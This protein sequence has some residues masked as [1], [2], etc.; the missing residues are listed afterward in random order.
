MQA[1]SPDSR[2]PLTQDFPNSVFQILVVDDDLLIHKSI[3]MA[4]PTQW[5]L[6]SATRLDE[7]PDQRFFHAACV[8]MHLSKDVS[9]P[10]DGP[11]IVQKLRHLNEQTEIIGMSGDL[12]LEL[13]ES[14]LKFGAQKFLSKPILKDELLLILEK[15]EA[16]WR[17]RTHQT[18]SATVKW[19]GNSAASQNI[20]KRISELKSVETP[21]LI[22]GDTG[23]GKEVV[24]KLLHAQEGPRPLVIVNL[25][26]IAENLF[27]S[28]FFGHIKGAFSGAT[29]NKIGLVEAANGGDLFMDEIEALHPAHQPKLLRFL[30]NGEVK[31]VGAKETSLVQVRVIAASNINL[32]E[33]VHKGLFREDLYYRL[34]ANQ[35]QLP[36]LKDRAMDI[37]QLCAHF[38]SLEKVKKTKSIS[39]DALELMK[40]YEWPGNTRELKR[41]CE[42]I[43]LAS[44]L[45]IIRSADVAPLLGI[46][47]D[48]TLKNQPSLPFDL[49]DS[50]QIE[51]GF[52]ELV[53]VFET[54][55]IKIALKKYPDVERAAEVLK[56]SRSNLYKKMKDYK[57]NS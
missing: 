44:P 2:H 50:L 20:Q 42:Q 22:E 39:H 30:E 5:K 33:M 8:D 49:K 29:Q 10:P 56:V 35:I 27:E 25:G 13:M 12:S 40:K 38:F 41:I 47:T 16:L 36:K 7:I 15:V 1:Q 4:L 45:P 19:I 11:K 37:E 48:E 21:V 6:T 23:T 54:Q 3:K 9:Q 31:K 14:C 52:E 26:A 34:C 55:L 53:Q 28:E 24:A 46:S 51:L 32:K 18:A 43:Y 57:I 17:L